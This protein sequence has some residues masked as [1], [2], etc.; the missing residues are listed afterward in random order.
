MNPNSSFDPRP[1]EATPVDE[2]AA[3]EWPGLK[4]GGD[5]V[6]NV[7]FP[8]E[9]GGR[10][11]AAMAAT[12]LDAALQLLADRAQYITGA[13]GAAIA[14]RDGAEMV[15][16]ASAGSSAPEVGARLQTDSGLSG[17]SI[18]TRETLR[19][20]DAQTDGRVN[21][22]SCE[23]LGIA[24]VVVM[25]MIEGE[26][27]VGVFELFSDRAYAFEERDIT[28]LERMGFMVR[29]AIAQAESAWLGTA[30][31]TSRNEPQPGVELWDEGTEPAEAIAEEPIPSAME[32]PSDASLSNE[33]MAVAPESAVHEGEASGGGPAS[34]EKVSHTGDVKDDEGTVERP[35]RIAFHIRGPVPRK[36]ALAPASQAKSEEIVEP[37]PHASVHASEVVSV[38]P[39]MEKVDAE[40]SALEPPI[41]QAEAGREEASRVGAASVNNW[42]A[43][44]APAKAPLQ[45]LGTMKAVAPAPETMEG[46]T[47]LVRSTPGPENAGVEPATLN[48]GMAILPD[49][50]KKSA[51][52]TK[53]S[54]KSEPATSGVPQSAAE[55]ATIGSAPASNDLP[56]NEPAPTSRSVER[57]RSA[58]ASLGR[59][60]TCGFPVSEGRRLCLDCEKKKREPGAVK[61]AVQSA[62]QSASPASSTEVKEAVPAPPAVAEKSTGSAEVSQA[63]SSTVDGPQFMTSQPDRYESW[64]VSHMY[65]AV[66][67]AVILIG[68]IVYLVSR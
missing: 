12:D 13:T 22:E 26:E 8:A 24:S 59:C 29:T 65:A 18:R 28:A 6:E 61:P 23:A 25:P 30:S 39:V 64:I 43:A 48:F 55:A 2:S 5:E 19:C 67:A 38:E 49:S 27:V 14:I 46:P 41:V 60:E 56:K 15:C 32:Q 63:A 31:A 20:D 33:G 7:R 11:L 10:S 1:A 36:P 42:G 52:E 40:P 17:E 21:R 68:V 58:V 16:R 47:S 37:T 62:V 54:P 50:T 51:G 44:V 57:A 66:A 53:A 35:S 34:V 3:R 45:T 9:D 4:R